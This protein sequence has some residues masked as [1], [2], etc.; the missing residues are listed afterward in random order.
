[1]PPEEKSIR[2]EI[3]HHRCHTGLL[4]TTPARQSGVPAPPCANL[5]SYRWLKHCDGLF[6]TALAA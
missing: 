4:G 6:Q 3:N 1:M 5:T 2:E